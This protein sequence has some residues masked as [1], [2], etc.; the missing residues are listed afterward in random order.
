[1]ATRKRVFINLQSEFISKTMHRAHLTIATKRYY[2]VYQA[3]FSNAY[4]NS[5]LQGFVLNVISDE[6]PNAGDVAI[7]R[8]VHCGTKQG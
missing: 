4:P 5:E 6:F 1:M 7:L 8:K 3:Y 2:R